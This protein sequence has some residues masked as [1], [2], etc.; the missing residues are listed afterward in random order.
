MCG[1]PDLLDE[2]NK[3]D[4]EFSFDKGFSHAHS[5]SVAQGDKVVRS[6]ELPLMVQEPFFRGGNLIFSSKFHLSG[7]N[8]SGWSHSSGSLRNFFMLVMAML[9][10]GTTC[11]VGNLVWGRVVCENWNSVTYRFCHSMLNPWD[12]YSRNSLDLSCI[13]CQTTLYRCR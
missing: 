4:E 3:E 2:S 10:S 13:K 7:L 9:P 5:L 12:G 6:E 11:P 1:S 8:C